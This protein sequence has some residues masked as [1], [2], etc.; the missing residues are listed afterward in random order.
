METGETPNEEYL[1]DLIEQKG[2]GTIEQDSEGENV[3]LPQYEGDAIK[4]SE[5]LGWEN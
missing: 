1:I 5:I 2:Y 3:L 4:L